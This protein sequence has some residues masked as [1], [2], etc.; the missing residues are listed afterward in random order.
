MDLFNLLHQYYNEKI[1]EIVNDLNIDL[2]FD[3]VK[4]IFYEGFKAGASLDTSIIVDLNLEVIR[5]PN[6]K[7]QSQNY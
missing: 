1:K 4:Q 2:D 5:F 3:T 6:L 7:K